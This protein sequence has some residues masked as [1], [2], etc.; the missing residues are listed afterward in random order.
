MGGAVDI[1]RPPGVANFASSV[2][3]EVV[4]AF[5][6]SPLFLLMPWAVGQ[7]MLKSDIAYSGPLDLR[8]LNDLSLW[9]GWPHY[10]RTALG[11]AIFVVLAFQ[12]EVRFWTIRGAA[13]EYCEVIRCLRRGEA[14]LGDEYLKEHQE[15]GF[16]W[17]F[18]R[19]GVLR[20]M[21]AEDTVSRK[22]YCWHF[23]PGFFDT[24][25]GSRQ[26][27]T[28]E[29]LLSAGSVSAKTF[30]ELEKIAEALKHQDPF[31]GGQLKEFA[32]QRKMKLRAEEEAAI[33]ER[34]ARCHH[35]WKHSGDETWDVHYHYELCWKCLVRRSG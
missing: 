14:Q 31:L 19:S 28:V 25:L 10:G 29:A 22:S 5:T 33:L 1:D 4:F 13:N 26:L 7:S 24:A 17:V 35:G 3:L 8:K 23:A 6:A 21:R 18:A 11:L 34:Q 15:K 12:T 9:R 20:W 2:A 16:R 30:D 32:S 27:G